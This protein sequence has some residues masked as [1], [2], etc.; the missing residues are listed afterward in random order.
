MTYNLELINEA[1]IFVES[2]MSEMPGDH[3]Y[4]HVKRVYEISNVILD[5]VGGDKEIVN[6]AS[7]FHDV[8]DHKFSGDDEA[9]GKS[10]ENFL[11]GKIDN[12]RID[13]IK[14]IVSNMSWSKNIDD[15]SPY[16]NKEFH[17]VQ[18]AD[19][20]D[21][22]GAIGIARTF[23]FGGYKKLPLYSPDHDLYDPEGNYG[24]QHIHQKY[25]KV[26]GSLHFDIS[27]QIAKPRHD[28]V[29]KFANQF[30]KEWYGQDYK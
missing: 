26:Y 9:S 12:S 17:I 13:W 24:L 25:F 15:I 23:S 30:K 18:D 11:K 22:L 6:L 4:S 29:V 20:I 10:A 14:A 19:R 21:A 27:R 3:D 28:F 1:K 16:G 5:S 8:A 2:A 7:L